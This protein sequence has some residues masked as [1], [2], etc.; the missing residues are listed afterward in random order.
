MLAPDTASVVERRLDDGA[1][2][3]VG[4]VPAGYRAW[5]VDDLPE[6]WLPVL[7]W[8]LSVELWDPAWT[9]AERRAAILSAVAQHREKGTPAGVKR[10][11][12]FVGAIYDYA[13]GPAP[14][15]CT[16]TIHNLGTLA[17]DG[18]AALRSQLDR[19]KR[20]SVACTVAAPGSGVMADA[21]MAAGVGAVLVRSRAL[22]VGDELQLTAAGLAAV[23]DPANTVTFTLMAVGAGR[24]QS[25]VDDSGRTALRDELQRSGLGGVTPAASRIAAKASFAAQAGVP[26]REIAEV[27]LIARVGAGAE[28]LAAYGAAAAG[29]DAYAAMAPGLST[30]LAT[31]VEVRA[32][33]A[34][35]DVAAAAAV[36]AT[37]VTTFAG[38][39]DTPAALTAE[40][41]YRADAAG[42]VLGARS[43]AEVLAELLGG[44]DDDDFLRVTAG[45]GLVGLSAAEV[46]EDLRA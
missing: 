38:L 13:E 2:N 43:A 15:T 17:V 7:A 3:R 1:G 12:D 16:I 25:G 9:V 22:V 28:F 37:G 5:C 39:T 19:A 32:G 45:G 36:A 30:V 18:L 35:V 20:A 14:F 34:D 42:A 6:S 27:G 31:V 46:G 8:A 24:A 10:A 33:Q 44:L 26:V 40:A 4:R 11:L 29:A 21:A 23:D 41:Y